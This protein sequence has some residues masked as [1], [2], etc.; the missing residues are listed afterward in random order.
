[1]RFPIYKNEQPHQEEYSKTS[2]DLA[3]EFTKLLHKEMGKFVRAVVLFGSAVRKKDSK[4]SDID[5]LVIID[6]VTVQLTKPL[7]EAYRI[8]IAKCVAKV[9]NKLHVVS[10]RFSGFWEYMRLGDPVGINILRD[11][12]AI[13]DTG[14]F[15]PMQHLLA[16]GFVRPSREAIWA[17][18]VMAPRTL[19]NSQFMINRAAME[20]YWAAIDSGHAAL[21]SIGELPPSPDHVADLIEQKLVKR[22]HVP[23]K[24]VTIMRSLYSLNKN[25]E[26]GGYSLSGKDYDQYAKDATLFVKEMKKIIERTTFKSR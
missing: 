23:R 10:L 16:R 24:M 3:Y 11:G 4:S 2:K 26:R 20:L 17:Y 7:V 15:T 14:F 12:L 5:V 8:I 6:D 18:Y 19:T 9:S 21:M 22:G 1:M 25:V 13:L